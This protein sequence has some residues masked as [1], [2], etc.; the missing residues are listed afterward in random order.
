L[1][2]ALLGGCGSDAA[3]TE[4]AETA[5]IR[6]AVY[7]GVLRYFADV[8]V[9]CVSLTRLDASGKPVPPRHDADPLLLARLQSHHADVR[10]ESDCEISANSEI[11][12]SR[13]A[14]EPAMFVHFGPIRFPSRGRAGTF[15]TTYSS[16]MASKAWDCS[17]RKREGRWQSDACAVS[18]TQV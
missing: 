1:S 7:A 4:G 10:R 13:N 15:I 16:R 18:A 3:I 17:L 6:D 9:H 12:R 2:F 8:P 11:V 14:H 5:A